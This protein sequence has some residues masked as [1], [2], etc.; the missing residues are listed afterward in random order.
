MPAVLGWRIQVGRAWGHT[1][2]EERFEGKPAVRGDV[3]RSLWVRMREME[4]KADV[5]AGAHHPARTQN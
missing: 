3:V 5:G 4:N 2:G 1:W